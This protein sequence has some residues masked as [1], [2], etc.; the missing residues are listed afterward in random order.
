MS[1]DRP[2]WEQL[3]WKFTSVILLAVALVCAGWAGF[4]SGRAAA[5]RKK[6]DELARAI[7]AP[8]RGYVDQAQQ[9]EIATATYGANVINIA[10][11]NATA[12][13]K[14]EA[15]RTVAQTLNAEM[16]AAIAPFLAAKGKNEDCRTAHR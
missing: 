1:I 13:Q 3:T 15:A 7:E 6:A 4:E 11:A 16:R 9:L 5:D 10:G 12:A 14:A 8:L 2:D